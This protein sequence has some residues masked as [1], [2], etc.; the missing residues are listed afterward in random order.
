[1]AIDPED[2]NTIYA[3]TERYFSPNGVINTTD[4]G[5]T[6]EALDEG[7]PHSTFFTVLVIDSQKSRTIYAGATAGLFALTRNDEQR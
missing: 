1:L 2:G 7:L 3:A 4:G 5:T 6:W